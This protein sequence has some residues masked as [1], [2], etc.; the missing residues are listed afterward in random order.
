[1]TDNAVADGDCVAITWTLR[2]TNTGP[3]GAMPPTG[4]RV[5]TRALTVYHFKDGQIAG[6]TQVVDR[7]AIARQLGLAGGLPA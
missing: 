1:M 4:R 7:V 3:L 2:G 6:H 5:E